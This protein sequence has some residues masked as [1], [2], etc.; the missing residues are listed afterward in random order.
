MRDEGFDC[1]PTS[2]V[3]AL[4]A[5]RLGDALFWAGRY[6]LFVQWSPDGSHP[7]DAAP[8]AGAAVELE[9]GV[10][11]GSAEPVVLLGGEPLRGVTFTGGVLRAT[12]PVVW[13]AP[14]GSEVPVTFE[15]AMSAFFGYGSP[16]A[17][18]PAAPPAYVGLQCHG[19]LWPADPASA[20]AA[21]PVTPPAVSGKV[22]AATRAAA[23]RPGACD[24]LAAFAGS[25]A[26]HALPDAPGGSPA[27]LADVVVE[28]DPAAA[29]GARVSVGGS[30]VTRWTFDAGNV[31]AWEGDAGC[32]AWLQFLALATGPVFVGNLFAAGAQ[33]PAAG[34]N[35][36]GEPAGGPSRL[37]PSGRVPGE[38]ARHVVASAAAA[39]ALLSGALLRSACMAWA[40]LRAGASAEDVL[41]SH[42]A[43][44][45]AMRRD[46][47]A[48]DRVHDVGGAAAAAFGGS[49]LAAPPALDLGAVA[50]ARAA[51]DE[52]A[53]H[54]AAARVAADAAEGAAAAAASAEAAGAAAEATSKAAVT[55]WRSSQAAAAAAAA[56]AAAARAC[57]AAARTRASAASAAAA[58]AAQA[59]NA[60]RAA[61]GGAAAGGSEACAAALR[62]VEANIATFARQREYLKLKDVAEA[63]DVA[64][65][66]LEAA[67]AAEA[68][69]AANTADTRCAAVDA[70]RGAAEA[71]ES[72]HR[73][74]RAI[75][76]KE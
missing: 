41:T 18:A 17:A 74:L 2:V 57:D 66:A 11:P 72:C 25:Y 60:A 22:N 9:V 32:S 30:P 47:E 20:P 15:L 38:E 10:A 73:V 69:W 68:G 36:F 35:A 70:A 54:A 43:M 14:D 29:G 58:A 42:D 71:A 21:W 6:A 40:E 4:D 16:D 23:V 67:R 61:A 39:G 1:P 59:Y 55:A 45:H 49:S 33:P 52:A 31:L 19:V 53:A 8:G 48:L 44:L 12:Q 37:P 64:G 51:A 26:V 13:A 50:G 5:A 63:S 7:W 62:A 28:A 75:D 27:E 56:E 24:A 3:E 34:F 76:K 46:F 65:R